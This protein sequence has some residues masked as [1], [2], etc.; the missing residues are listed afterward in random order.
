MFELYTIN[1][2]TYKREVLIDSYVSL[3]W[4]ERYIEAG[5]VTL[6]VPATHDNIK[7]LALG[8]L[9]ELRNSREPMLI[10]TR[11]IEDG[12]LTV[13]GNTL[14][15]VFNDRVYP[16]IST[17]LLQAYETE[18]GPV[19]E[20]RA[21][22]IAHDN[23]QNHKRNLLNGKPG[24]VMGQI[25]KKM[26]APSPFEVS[27]GLPPFINVD[28]DEYMASSGPIIEQIMPEKDA[29]DFLLDM[30]KTYN[31]D[32]SVRLD[33][34]TAP[35]P[36][37]LVFSTRD[38]I[39]LTS[40]GVNAYRMVRFSPNL[41]NFASIKELRS[42]SDLKNVVIMR[43]PT[44]IAWMKPWR[45]RMYSLKSVFYD[46]NNNASS[47]QGSSRDTSIRS[48]DYAFYFNYDYGN[49]LPT[50]VQGFNTETLHWYR[51]DRPAFN[52]PFK[53]REIFVDCEDITEDMLGDS[54]DS[55]LTKLNVLLKLMKKKAKSTLKEHNKVDMLDGEVPPTPSYTDGDIPLTSFYEYKQNYKLG[56]LVEM[57]GYYGNLVTGRV[58]EYIR[59]SDNTGIREYPTLVAEDPVIEA[60]SVVGGAVWLPDGV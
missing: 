53:I 52:N 22:N 14:E 34:N 40:K 27:N 60:V 35:T 45:L 58:T 44:K 30:A 23:E 6:I 21:Y 46:L 42:I 37:K 1:F 17:Y 20:N 49:L 4:T 54:N 50:N 12:T 56:D 18:Y 11:S 5:D 39:D 3:I 19:P 43:P 16:H 33:H 59:S 2:S 55:N 29:Y 28:P 47:Y 31:I 15:K 26:L 32:M 25:V 36:N 57:E 7:L 41:Q 24:I 13:T 8:S 48:G 51:F 9:L 10:H 38:G